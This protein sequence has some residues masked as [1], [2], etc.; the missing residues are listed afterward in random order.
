LT[1]YRWTNSL[2]RRVA[3]KVGSLRVADYFLRERTG[4]ATPKDML[5]YLRCAPKVAPNVDDMA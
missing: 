5:K 4:T 1:A 2:R 3:E